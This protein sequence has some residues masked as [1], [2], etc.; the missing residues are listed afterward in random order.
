MAR[1][2]DQPLP[3]YGDLM[4]AEEFTACVD[5]GSFIPDDGTGYWVKDGLE[6]RDE[7]FASEV[8]DATHVMWYN[9]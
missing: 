6:S 5:S 9:K 1:T 2:Y 8:E 4:T 7:V 3:D